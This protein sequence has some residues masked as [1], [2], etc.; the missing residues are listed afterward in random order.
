MQRHWQ[1]HI[2]RFGL[3]R[4]RAEK[5]RLAAA[6]AAAKKE[7]EEGQVSSKE[8]GLHADAVATFLQAVWRGY[9]SRAFV[10]SIRQ[11]KVTIFGVLLLTF[12]V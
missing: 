7:E 6:A 9:L 11:R 10:K 4:K 12:D 8:L 1:A 3:K 2:A 5:R